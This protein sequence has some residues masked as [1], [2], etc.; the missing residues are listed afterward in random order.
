MKKL[1]FYGTL[2]FAFLC[3]NSSL[4]LAQDSQ[5]KFYGAS[6]G[7]G[8]WSGG[9][10]YVDPELDINLDLSTRLNKNLFSVF[11]SIGSEQALLGLSEQYSQVNLTYG[12]LFKIS[13]SF[14]FEAHAGA[15]LISYKSSTSES[16]FE[17]V[18]ESAIG[19]PVRVKFNYYFI[20]QLGIG[21]NLNLN[22]NA[23]NN[24]V[25]LNSILQYRF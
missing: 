17:E 18:S 16:D 15:G 20:E 10:N 11:A 25:S 3:F 12:R 14:T 24:I 6:I 1:T 9:V 21:V 2:L 13:N 19:F 7:V 8:I 23:A 5:L 4:L 22:K